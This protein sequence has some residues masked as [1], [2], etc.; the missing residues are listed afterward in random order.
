LANLFNVIVIL[1]TEKMPDEWKLGH[2]C[3]FRRQKAT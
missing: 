1:E 2:L 3:C